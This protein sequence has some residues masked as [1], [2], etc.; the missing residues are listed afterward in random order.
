[1]IDWI[2]DHIP[3]WVWLVGLGAALIATYPMWSAIWA[4]LPRPVKLLLVALVAGAAA[5][6]AGRNRGTKDAKAAQDK[7][8]AQATKR[9]LETNAEVTNLDPATR[10]R[11][12]DKWLRD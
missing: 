5:Y 8:N 3:Y 11:E 2:F 1:V 12:F 6:L 4:L 9:R 10:K 7:A